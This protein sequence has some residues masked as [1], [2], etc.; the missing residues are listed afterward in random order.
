M[1]Y[2]KIDKQ[3]IYYCNYVNTDLKKKKKKSWEK[4]LKKHLQRNHNQKYKNL[5]FLQIFQIV[6]VK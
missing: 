2:R 4:I 3:K 5:N 1:Y 6:R